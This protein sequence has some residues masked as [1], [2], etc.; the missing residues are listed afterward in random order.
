MSKLMV[1]DDEVCIAMYL[2]ERLENMGHEVVGTA[3]SGESARDMAEQRR[4]NLVLMDIRM[5]GRLGGIEAAEIIIKEMN[6]PVIFI[7]GYADDNYVNRAKSIG[8]YGYLIKPLDDGQLNATVGIALSKKELEEKLQQARLNLEKI[9]DMRTAELRIATGKLKEELNEK[10]RLIKE[11]RVTSYAIESSIN[12]I[13]IAELSGNITYINKPFLKMWGY[14][15]K[16]DVLG[17][18]FSEFLTNREDAFAVM[19]A[20]VENGMWSG[21]MAA[22]KKDGEEF[23]AHLSASMIKDAKA[24]NVH[25]MVSVIDITKR[26]QAQRSL[27]ESKRELKIRAANL[28]ETNTALKV[29]LKKRDE[30]KSDLE[31]NIAFSVRQNVVPYIKELAGSDLDNRQKTAL[32]T[33]ELNLNNIISPFSRR[34]SALSRYLTPTEVRIANLVKEGK[35]TKQIAQL[36]DCSARAVEFHRNNIRRQFNLINQKTNL[37][38]YLLSLE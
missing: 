23:D 15:N 31:D 21:E 36:L 22:R 25:M 7:T 20:L 6:I 24:K 9:V 2:K 33:I 34:L 14:D 10:K 38:S 26:K 12:A 17:R 16:N 13:G 8:S 4:P 28:E 18:N 35:T 32:N 30:F 5:P 19:D 3:S 11:L 37:R 29:L 1:V 27:L